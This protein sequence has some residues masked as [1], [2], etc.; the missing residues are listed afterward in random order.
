[1]IA[2]SPTD[3]QAMALSA[4]VAFTA[5]LV[6]IPFGF[7]AAYLLVFSRL[8]GKPLLNGMVSLPLVLPPVVVGYL[9]L[10]SLGNHGWLGA[11]LADMGIRIIFTWKAAVIASMVVGFPLLVRS[12]CI[13]MEEIDDSLIQAS[14][15]LG[16]RWYDTLFTVILPL[17]ARAILAGATLMFA[18][19]LGEF[20]ATIVLA[21]NIPGVTQTIPLAIFDY[22]STP[23][24]DRMALG[25][26]LVSI[27]LAL[28]VLIFNEGM[29]RRFKRGHR[30]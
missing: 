6:S 1:M 12:I 21:G 18:R 27:G 9:L 29:I 11:M 7:A 2:F 17:S 8:P 23:G 25:L 26:C 14:R 13:G 3:V 19:S 30:P 10:L 22:T 5:T 20:G 24:G 4:R 28:T 15:T 16:A